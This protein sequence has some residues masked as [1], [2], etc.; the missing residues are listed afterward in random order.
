MVKYDINK[1]KTSFFN[2]VNSFHIILSKTFLNF[3]SFIFGQ[4]KIYRFNEI[5]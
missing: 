4:A 2:F 1:I 5:F 3:W